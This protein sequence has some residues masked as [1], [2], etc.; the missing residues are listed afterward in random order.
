V[1]LSRSGWRKDGCHSFGHALG[2]IGRH[3]NACNTVTGHAI[4]QATT[5]QSERLRRGLT[6]Q[7]SSGE[8]H[9]DTALLAAPH[10]RL[11]RGMIVETRTGQ[12]LRH[13]IPQPIKPA[14]M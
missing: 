2:N 10:I 11:G 1:W 9:E 14:Y 4:E 7:F 8:R 6:P 5:A 12:A 3:P 13:D